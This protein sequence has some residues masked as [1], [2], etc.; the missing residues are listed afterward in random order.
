[1]Q[2]KT[3]PYIPIAE[4]RGFTAKMINR[5]I[6]KTRNLSP[7]W[8]LLFWRGDGTWRTAWRYSRWGIA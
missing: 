4:A 7:F 1:M 8:G 6:K 3:S 2:Q 5:K